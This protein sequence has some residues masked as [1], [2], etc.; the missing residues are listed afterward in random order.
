[1]TMQMNDVASYSATLTQNHAVSVIYFKLLYFFTFM[2][3][4][5]LKA[6]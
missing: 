4:Q 2:F 1:M 6:M 3:Y 5:L